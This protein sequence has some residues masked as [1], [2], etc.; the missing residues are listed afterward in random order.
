MRYLLWIPATIAYYIIYSLL[1]KKHNL[2]EGVDKWTIIMFVY[3][4]LCPIWLIVSKIS[5]NLLFDG[6]LY[7]IIIFLTFAITIAIVDRVYNLA[8]HQ[9]IGAFFVVVGFILMRLG[10]GIFSHL[11]K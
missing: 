10:S 5:K 11:F 3:G 1:A 7:D 9:I 8:W 4:A 2:T 6:M